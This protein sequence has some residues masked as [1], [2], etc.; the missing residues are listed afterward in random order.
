[1]TDTSATPFDFLALAEAW[2]PFAAVAGIPPNYSGD[3][4]PAAHEGAEKAQQLLREHI[5]ATNDYRLFPLLHL[6][7]N[8]SLRME[9]VLDPEGYA[10]LEARIT[11]AL[12]EAELHATQGEGG[13]PGKVLA[14][15]LL[16]RD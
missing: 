16:R 3:S 6:L 12:A 2:V 1:M 13:P 4:T 8:A 15:S 7:G 11:E 10:E 5:T 9:Q 14:T